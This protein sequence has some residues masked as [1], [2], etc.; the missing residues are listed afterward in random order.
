[1]GNTA[2]A[3]TWEDNVYLFEENDPVQGGAD[4][5][6]NV[7]I[8]QLA[9]RTAYL[10]Q[11][12]AQLAQTIPGTDEFEKIYREIAALNVT[13]VE[14]RVDH[15]ERLTGNIML[16]LQAGNMSPDGYDGMMT[17]TFDTAAEIDQIVTIVTSVVSGDDSIDVE[18]A[19]GIVIGAHYQLTDGES[20]EEVQ[21]KSLNIAGS[22]NRVIFEDVVKNQYVAG[23]AKLYRSS[24]AIYNGKAYGGGNLKT[25]TWEA[26]KTWSGSTT[27]QSVSAETVYKNDSDFIVT[28]ATFENGVLVLGSAVV[29][30]SLAATGGGSGIWKQIDEWGDNV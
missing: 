2:G 15:L 27:A 17:E 3:A 22:I 30:V 25:D 23:R 7:P 10:K 29:G 24:V 28:G 20:M 1:M 8:K 14:G 26:A 6:D 21:V 5:I 4:G 16:A 11:L 18:N 9:N 13:K 12:C 19:N